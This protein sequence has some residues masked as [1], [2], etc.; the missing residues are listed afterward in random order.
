MELLKQRI[1]KDGHVKPGNIIKVD[2]FLNHQMDIVLMN[3]IGKEFARLFADQPITKVLT[4][5]ASGIGIAAIAAQH[6]GNAPVVFA[7]KTQSKN[8]DGELYISQVESFTRGTVCDIQVS[9]KFITSD[10]CV[11]ILDDFLAKGKALLGLI[12]IVK[13][14]GAKFAGCGIVI[15]K[16]WQDGG[17]V[18]REKGI[19]LESLAIIDKADETGFTFRD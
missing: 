1:M 14:S 12:D 5:E 13:Q 11:L 19:R 18:L 16:G 9:K 10:D 17:E 7:K 3:E 2:S 6:F 15:E 4:I 8:L